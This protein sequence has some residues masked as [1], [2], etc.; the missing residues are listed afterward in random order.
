MLGSRATISAPWLILRS[1]VLQL[2]LSDFTPAINRHLHF[3]EEDFVLLVSTAP[4]HLVIQL[5]D[6]LVLK[7]QLDRASVNNRR[8]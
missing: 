2:A 8:G 5:G 7:L 6:D 4:L 3:L 1:A